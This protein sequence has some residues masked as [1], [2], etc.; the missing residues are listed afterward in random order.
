MNLGKILNR[1]TV[2]FGGLV[3]T[4][5]IGLMQHNW[6]IVGLVILA[7]VY[8]LSLAQKFLVRILQNFAD[9]P[10]W[11][12][13]VTLGIAILIAAAKADWFIIIFLLTAMDGNFFEALY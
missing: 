1:N 4:T 8:E 7:A 13:F 6:V 2:L 11:P 12:R 9:V 10:V 3:L 5:V